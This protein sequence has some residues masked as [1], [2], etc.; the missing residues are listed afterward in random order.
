MIKLPL[1]AVARALRL[2]FI[3]DIPVALWDFVGVGKS[4]VVAQ[5]VPKGWGLYDVRLSDK[6]ASDLGGI[7]Y[8]VEQQPAEPKGKAK[9]VKMAPGA[10]QVEGE[11]NPRI[12]RKVEY[13]MSSLLPFDSEEKCVVLF[14]EFDRTPDLSVQNAA[15]QLVLDRRINGHYLSKGA[16]IVI[17]GNG[18]TDQGTIPL[19]SAS[20]NRMGHLY[21]DSKSDRAI[22]AWLE[23]AKGCS[24][25]SPELQSFA[26]Y[27]SEVWHG[28]QDPRRQL[29]EYGFPT[30]RSF[31][32][33]DKL[34]RV[35]QEIQAERDREAIKGKTGKEL[36]GFEVADIIL[37]TMAGCVGQSAAVEMLGWFAICKEAP[38][39]EEIAKDPAGCRLPSQHGI[40]F[41]LGV[42][43]A[44]NAKGQSTKVIDAFA[45]YVARWPKEQAAAGFSYL[46]NE[47]SKAASSPHY[48]A[49]QQASG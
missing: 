10:P 7:P 13:L 38:K 2:H 25:V 20:A 41:A 30:P 18:N 49:W 17:A 40:M 42:T 6:E 21:V 34:W 16:R 28:K 47:E 11:G 43:M 23:W 29:E 15:L 35:S 8:P 44:R 33:A 19:T 5:S 37:P 48:L 24:D 31:V 3:A 39:L 12:I 45:Q 36:P 46:L 27:K 22:E 4:S 26:S 9:A 32:M 1:T 14:D